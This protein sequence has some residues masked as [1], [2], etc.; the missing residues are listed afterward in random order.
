MRLV[1]LSFA[2][3][4]IAPLAA[5]TD[6][7]STDELAADD[8]TVG[9]DSKADFA[10]G[11]YTYYFVTE[12]FRRC[13]SPFCSGAFYRL[14]NA[15]K[16]TCAD[17]TKAE[18]CYAASEDW[19]KLNLGPV[20]QDKV[21]AALGPLGGEILVRATIAKKDWG[22]GL[23]KFAHLNVREAWLPQGPNAP[24]GPV[25]RVEDS[26][27]RCITFP[28]P[29]LREKKLNSSATASLAELG[30]AESNATDEQI[31]NGLDKMATDGLIIAGTRYTVT[32]P[33]G[34]GKART[35]SQFYLR[36]TDEV[37]AKTCIKTGCSGQICSDES[38]ITTCQFLPEY[39]CYQT[40]TC[41]AQADGECGWTETAELTS[42]LAN[43]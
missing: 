42:C 6:D 4:L 3:A 11:V 15:T 18:R 39:A 25:A 43:P 1:K 17:G 37:V 16:T 31:S 41:E 14:A 10:G 23:G 35:V 29:S 12:D 7:T 13:A 9:E 33:G 28:C 5:C 40:A 20:G 26:G 24:E 21:S 34:S 22:N 19:T 36:A 30:W 27:I 38:R 2:L 8:A 32:G